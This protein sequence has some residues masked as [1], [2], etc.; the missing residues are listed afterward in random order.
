MGTMVIGSVWR[1]AS[2][3]SSFANS[4]GPPPPEPRTPA[5]RAMASRSAGVSTHG[6]RGAGSTFTGNPDAQRAECLDPDTGDVAGQIGE[7]RV[8]GPGYPHRGRIRPRRHGLADR[9]GDS[10]GQRLLA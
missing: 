5:P 10:Q 2:R 8:L 6:W 4:A 7:R 1:S 9:L 3:T